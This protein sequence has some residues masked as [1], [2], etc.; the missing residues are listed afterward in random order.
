MKGQLN[1]I[2]ALV[3]TLFIASFSVLNVEPV[4]VNFLISAA[5]IPLIIVIIGSALIGGVI[6]GSVGLFRQFQLLREIKLLRQKVQAELGEA[7]LL[8]ID[9]TLKGRKLQPKPTEQ[10]KLI[11]QELARA[12]E[13]VDTLNIEAKSSGEAEKEKP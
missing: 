5:T 13:I 12:S 1:L 11:E 10:D 7:V 2:L 9:E 3:F 4:P 8:E 6:V